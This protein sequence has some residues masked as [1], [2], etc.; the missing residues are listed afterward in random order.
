MH[1]PSVAR[2]GFIAALASSLGLADGRD[3]SPAQILS[4]KRGPKPKGARWR[5]SSVHWPSG[6]RC[7]VERTSIRNPKIAANVQ[8]MHEKWLA[9]RNARLIHMGIRP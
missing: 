5:S 7:N 8:M 4:E 2:V 6:Q 3:Y 9:A 1:K